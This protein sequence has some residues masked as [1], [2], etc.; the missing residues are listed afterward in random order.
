M[1]VVRDDSE[2]AR[3]YAA[4]RGRATALLGG[5][6]LLFVPVAVLSHY[7]R[8]TPAPFSLGLIRPPAAPALVGG[9][10]DWFADTALVRHPRDLAI[11]PTPLVA[12]R[13]SRSGR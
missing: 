11:P 8:P 12:E 2:K 10:A 7:L 4:M 9:I 13:E 6:A 1:L 5:F 3:Q